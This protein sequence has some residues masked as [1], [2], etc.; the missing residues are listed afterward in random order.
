MQAHMTT[1]NLPLPEATSRRRALAMLGAG[2]GM[3]ALGMSLKPDGK[4]TSP[5]RGFDLSG[6]IPTQ[7][8]EWTEAAQTART[9]NPQTQA[10]LDKIYSQILERI[11]QNASGE[12]IMLAAAY[13]AD[14]RGTLEAHKPEVCYPAQGFVIKANEE[15]LLETDF[16][17]VAA[18]RLFAIAGNRHE[19]LTYWF[20]MSNHQVM[21]RTEKRLVEIKSALTG[22]IPDGLLVRVSSISKDPEHAWGVQKRFLNDLLHHLKPQ[23]RSRIAGLQG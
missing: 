11:Y 1:Q 17:V 20:T 4:N 18:R 22:Q 6:T 2:A 12:Q 14:Q 8:G 5:Q 10:L 3:A 9:V 16:G 13:G 15:V 23:A 21:S 19:P 7:F